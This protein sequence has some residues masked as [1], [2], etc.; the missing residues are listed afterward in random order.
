MDPRQLSFLFTQDHCAVIS[1]LV[2]VLEGDKQTIN[3]LLG[4]TEQMDPD[5]TQGIQPLLQ[6]IA[7][8]LLYINA[9]LR[10][11]YH[12]AISSYPSKRS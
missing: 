1:A 7:A 12:F 8:D 11:S 2:S 10:E 6:S 9:S 4:I 5:V 3:T